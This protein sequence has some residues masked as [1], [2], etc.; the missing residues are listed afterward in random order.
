[1]ENMGLSYVEAIGGKETTITVF[2]KT[3]G[4]S[5][6]LIDFESDAKL[7]AK[8][9]SEADKGHPARANAYMIAWLIERLSQNGD[10]ILDPTSGMGTSMIGTLMGRN[11]INIELERHFSDVQALNW[12]HLNYVMPELKAEF[13]E[14]TPDLGRFTLHEG[15]AKKIMTQ[16]PRYS[17]HCVIFSPPYGNALGRPGPKL[18]AA[19]MEAGT[20]IG[21]YGKNPDQ[22]GNLGYFKYGKAMEDVYSGCY[23]LLPPGGFMCTICKDMIDSKMA[24]LF[25]GGRMPI[26]VD[27][28]KW[29]AKAGFTMYEWWYRDAAPSMALRVAWKQNP[30]IPHVVTE[31]IIIMRKPQ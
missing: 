3:L 26:S 6:R 27:N 25:P 19:A 20:Y 22:I 12:G 24:E 13:P 23:E 15:D 29:A 14:I 17:V 28:S 5:G 2:G 21:A 9:F 30:N 4:V 10:T 7:R 8:I 11:V 31:D 18:A 16:L 1:M